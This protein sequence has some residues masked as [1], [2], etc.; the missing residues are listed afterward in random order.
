[1]GLSIQHPNTVSDGGFRFAPW[2]RRLLAGLVDALLVGVV[3]GLWVVVVRT[4]P[5]WIGPQPEDLGNGL[6]YA[7]A[8]EDRRNITRWLTA[9]MLLSTAIVVV[10]NTIIAQGITGRTL[11]KRITG[12]I[13]IDPG[14]GRPVGA[15]RALLR[16]LA[17]IADALPCYLGYFWPLFD[18][19][20]RTF[21]D[22][23]ART[24]VVRD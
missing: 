14:T 3:F 17:H 24:V 10:A 16:Q 12:Q 13:L 7:E 8:I 22:I 9:A 23:A 21:A 20:R 2:H 19:Q 11:G 6:G 1:M 5:E 15:G 18:E 4:S